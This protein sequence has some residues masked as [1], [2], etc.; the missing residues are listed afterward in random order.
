MKT[1]L[2]RWWCIKNTNHIIRKWFAKKYKV[3]DI[4]KWKYDYIGYDEVRTYNG[5]LGAPLT[6]FN[7][8]NIE[9]TLE[10]FK[11]LVLKQEEKPSKYLKQ[12]L[13]K[14]KIK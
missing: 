6:S 11:R 9:I 5:V 13:I 14:L 12:L 1:E 3:P 10:E 7:H 2:P 4:L 8:K